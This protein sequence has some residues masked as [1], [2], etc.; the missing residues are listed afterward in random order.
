[1]YTTGKEVIFLL[2]E[3]FAKMGEYAAMG[4]YEEEGRDLFYRKA[5]GIRR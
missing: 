3:E 4:A 2:C 5:L 1:M